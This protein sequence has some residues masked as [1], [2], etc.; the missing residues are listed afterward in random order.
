MRK[1][2]NYKGCVVSFPLFKGHLKY[3]AAS[4]IKMLHCNVENILAPQD[5]D[6]VIDAVEREVDKGFLTDEIIRAVSNHEMFLSKV[7]A[8]P[9]SVTIKEAFA[10][11]EKDFKKK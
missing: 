10:L 2:L 6:A 3:E 1:R 7:F 8:A 4:A 9:E 5:A 11:A